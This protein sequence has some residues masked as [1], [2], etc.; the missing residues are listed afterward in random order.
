MES[1]LDLNAVWE[2]SS[3]DAEAL[4][5]IKTLAF[6]DSKSIDQ[7]RA[8]VN[9]VRS[10]NANPSGG[11]ALK[12][13]AAALLLGEPAESAALLESAEPSALQAMLLGQSYLELRRF[14][15]AADQFDKARK[16]GA[17]AMESDLHR[18]HALVLEGQHDEA[19]RLLDQ[20]KAAS[21][22]SSAWHFVAGR[23]AHAEGRLDEAFEH[24]DK[25]V[26]IDPRNAQAAFHLAYL[27]DL[28]GDDETAA[29]WYEAC[30]QLPVTYADALINLS[31]MHEDVGDYEA[32]A[33]CL[34]RVLAV[35]PTH[36]RANLYLKDVVASSDMYIDEQRQKVQEKRSAVLDT[37]V[38]DFELSVR[39]RNCLKKMNINTLGDLLRI[40]EAELL[41]YKNFGET[42]LREIKAML[43]QKGLTLGQNAQPGAPAFVP[44]P[45]DEDMEAEPAPDMK[46]QPVAALEL[47]VRSRKC[48]QMLGIETVGDLTM[49]SETELLESRNFGQTSLL[50][51]KKCLGDLG[52]SL[53]ST[54]V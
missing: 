49:R 48:L 1:T 40:T 18:A 47:S 39:S 38:T 3:F 13:G 33:Q 19:R 31:V 15:E 32:A 8:L 9:A 20:H 44:P 10:R 23:L 29:R 14:L 26:A 7:L 41:S 37:P 2:Q 11:D 42:S 4:E 22:E 53:R 52:L 17:N 28:H 50:E 35:N 27:S 12:L 6:E 16:A 21:V 25:S 45:D 24:L 5:Q 34:R 36:P 46:A 43:A 54:E 51:I 30:A